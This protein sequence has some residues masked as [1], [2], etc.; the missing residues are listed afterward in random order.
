M[1]PALRDLA[2]VLQ[3]HPLARLAWRAG[4]DA[5]RFLRDERP[6]LLEV[7]SKSTPTDSVTA[8]DRGSEL[9]IRAAILSERP[10]DA[11][12]GE[13]GGE[14]TGSTGV[15]WV[16]DPLD[17]TVNYVHRLPLWGVSIAVEEQGMAS[18]GVVVTP[19]LDEAYIAVRGQGAWR[20]RGAR[21]ERIHVSDCRVLDRALV[22]TGFDYD[23]GRRAEQ[24][25]VAGRLV[26][27]VADLRRSGSAVVDLCWLASGQVD[28]YFERGLNPWDLA[29]GAL[30]A[31][32][33]GAVVTGLT[34]EAPDG[35]VVASAPGIASQFRRSLRRLHEGLSPGA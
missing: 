12:L 4:G 29:A 14:R 30:I 18:V 6:L 24:G 27:E 10:D 11:I 19:V 7:E 15:R 13:E 21:A 28:A 1:P 35:V 22:A 9:L 2:E 17:G 3:W 26:A 23:A 25:A 16:I 31:H 34:A 8:M 20:V 5:A 33:A 32:E